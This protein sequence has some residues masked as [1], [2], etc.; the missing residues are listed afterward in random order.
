MFN[1]NL[2]LFWNVAVLNT[3]QAKRPS[4]AM[5]STAKENVWQGVLQKPKPAPHVI[6]TGGAGPVIA[7]DDTFQVGLSHSRKNF[8]LIEGKIS[9]V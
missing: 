9:E 4:T 2:N 6:G 8:I 3:G 1:N 5:D 7:P